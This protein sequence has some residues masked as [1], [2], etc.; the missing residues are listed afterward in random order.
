MLAAEDDDVFENT[1]SDVVINVPIQ[2]LPALQDASNDGVSEIEEITKL[3]EAWV[4]ARFIEKHLFYLKNPVKADEPWFVTFPPSHDEGPLHVYKK[5]DA[6]ISC[7]DWIVHYSEFNP[8]EFFAIVGCL[9]IHFTSSVGRI[10]FHAGKYLS[11]ISSSLG[12][13]INL[14]AVSLDGNSF[15]VTA[16]VCTVRATHY[17]AADRAIFSFKGL[18]GSE[19]VKN[20][21]NEMSY[22]SRCTLGVEFP[23]QLDDFLKRIH[24]PFLYSISHENAD[25]EVLA[26][27]GADHGIFISKYERTSNAA[28]IDGKFQAR[29]NG[30]VAFTVCCECKNRANLMYSDKLLEI[31]MKFAVHGAKLGLVFCTA[32]GSTTKPNAKFRVYCRKKRVNV[33]RV[34]LERVGGKY[35]VVPFTEDFEIHENPSNTCI[36]LE[37]SR[38]L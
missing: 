34:A 3:P 30:N 15:E 38:I 22:S 29:F 8:K 20:V 26:S 19:F 25:F 21:I 32:F 10:L 23:K 2:S 9:F 6:T 33:Y 31:L 18:I 28:Q 1:A 36:V 4:Q 7:D 17:T 14:N 16:A 13:S 11:S 5:I 35:N 24:V 12:Q 37:T 27:L